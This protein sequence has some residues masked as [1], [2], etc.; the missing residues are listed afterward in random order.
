MEY[1]S[2]EGAPI[3]GSLEAGCQAA[4]TMRV[5]TLRCC[6][7]VDPHCSSAPRALAV[8]AARAHLLPLTKLRVATITGS[9][10]LTIRM[11][12]SMLVELDLTLGVL[13]AEYMSTLSTMVLASEDSEWSLAGRCRAD[14]GRTIR[15]PVVPSNRPRDWG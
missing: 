4:D 11:E 1:Q 9:L 14:C 12:E 10:K 8:G 2:L 13:P 5:W 6:R 15:L 3:P 7:G